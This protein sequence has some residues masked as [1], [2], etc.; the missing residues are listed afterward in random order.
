MSDFSKDPFNNIIQ[1]G[2]KG[3]IE[4]CFGAQRYRASIILIYSAID[5]MASLTMPDTQVEVTRR[6]FIAWADKY[7]R[8]RG[9][10]APTGT[11]LYAAR[12]AVLHGYGV[13]SRLSRS[14]DARR[15][16]YMNESVPEVRYD[17]NI[18]PAT[19]GLSLGALKRA[20]FEGIDRCMIDLH[21]NPTKYPRTEER[22]AWM[23]MLRPNDSN[24]QETNV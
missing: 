6:D 7:I 8:I 2:I 21:T 16:F 23:I 19:M 15:I 18:D 4:H 11:E 9:P 1:E 5:S 22:L 17:A 13:E 20:V 10:N 24:E 14:G 3:D 12:C